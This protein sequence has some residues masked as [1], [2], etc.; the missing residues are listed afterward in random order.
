MQMSLFILN[1][2]KG[3]QVLIKEND[4]F[5]KWI[6]RKLDKVISMYA[7]NNKAFSII[8]NTDDIEINI[9]YKEN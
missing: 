5:T 2:N 4:N 3:F 1:I 7:I 6:F 8:H 9:K